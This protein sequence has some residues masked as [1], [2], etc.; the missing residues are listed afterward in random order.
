MNAAKT[1]CKMSWLLW[2][3]LLILP[4]CF[5]ACT[6]ELGEEKLALTDAPV[7]RTGNDGDN[8]DSIIS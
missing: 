5:Q 7:T 3:P 1:K 2:A 8:T 6:P 4:L